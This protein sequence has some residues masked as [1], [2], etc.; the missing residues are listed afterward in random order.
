MSSL[1]I[2]GL[3]MIAGL[4][5]LLG[6]G[7]PIAYAMI[8]IGLASL[9]W[10]QGWASADYLVGNFPYSS[11]AEFAFVIIPLFLFMGEMAY[12]SGLSERAFKVARTW[13]GHLPGGLP[14]ASVA[15]CAGFSAV[16]GSSIVTAATIGRISIPEMLKAGVSQRLA[17]GAVATAGALG[18]LIPPSGILVVYSI[19][20][21]VPVLDLFATAI[22]P[23][24]LTA[25]VYA[26]GIYIWVQ[27][28]PREK[29]ARTTHQAATW[30]EKTRSLKSG[31][32]ILLLFTVVMGSMLTGV[33]TPTEAAAVGAVTAGLIALLRGARFQSF[34]QGLIASGSS[35]AAVFMLI[36]GSGL[37]SLGFATTQIPQQ[38]ASMIS[39]LELSPVVLLILLLIP[40]LFLGMFLDAISMILLTMPL[41][42]PIVVENNINPI[43]FGIL[44]TKMAEIGNITPPVGLNV[45]VLKGA[46]P[47]IQISEVFKGAVPFIA[48]EFLLIALFILFPQIVLFPLSS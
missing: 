44:V 45:F 46:A 23:G 1:H 38:M 10:T 30:R 20:T 32:E 11:T 2:T 17:G 12:R 40:F 37:F 14:I 16:C 42:F 43:L 33:A 4:F 6:I 25:L 48:M 41:M 18:A 9:V 24:I 26:I 34:R 7:V 27:V 36:V 39:G 29:A 21:Q 19:A 15:A 5:F 8:A 13:I 35:S 47:E 22:V 3:A 28:S 31:W